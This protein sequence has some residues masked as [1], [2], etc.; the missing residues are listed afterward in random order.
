[1]HILFALFYC[2][3]IMSWS[4]IHVMDLP[5]FFK[6]ASL[7]LGNYTIAQLYIV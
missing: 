4:W 2:D 1:M 5:I 6:V 7:A 3:Y